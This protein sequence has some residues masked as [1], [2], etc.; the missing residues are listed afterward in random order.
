MHG[1]FEDEVASKIPSVSLSKL[2]SFVDEATLEP[3][4]VIRQPSM[5]SFVATA[6][7]SAPLF[8]S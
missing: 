8:P 2:D 7:S 1:R 3:F 5:C 6:C 4:I